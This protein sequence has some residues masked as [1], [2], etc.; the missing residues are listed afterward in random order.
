MLEGTTGHF[1]QLMR[2]ASIAERVDQSR[3]SRGKVPHPS[4]DDRQTRPQD[5]DQRKS[6]NLINNKHTVK[7]L[8]RC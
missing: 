7:I 5:F 1:V 4:P 3:V 6:K 8:L 2:S